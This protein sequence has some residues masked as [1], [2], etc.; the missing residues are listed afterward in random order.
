MLRAGV[1]ISKK[2]LFRFIGKRGPPPVSL[3]GT[4]TEQDA[5]TSSSSFAAAAPASASLAPSGEEP[6]PAASNNNQNNSRQGPGDLFQFYRLL[7]PSLD[8]E[9]GPY[10]LKETLLAK[11]LCHA[12]GR[13]P[14]SDPGAARVL[15]WQRDGAGATAG[16]LAHVARDELVSWWRGERVMEREE[17]ERERKKRKNSSSR[18]NQKNFKKKQFANGCTY[19]N[20]APLEERRLGIYDKP[21][22]RALTVGELNEQLDLLVR[23]ASRKGA[24]GR[25]GAAGGAGTGGGPSSS[26]LP[27]GDPDEEIGSRVSSAGKVLR[28]LMGKTSARTMTWIVKIILCGE[29]E[30]E[31]F[32]FDLFLRLFSSLF[33]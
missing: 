5:S 29:Q 16:S 23:R 19:K 12:L 22:Y 28:D 25:G 27:A 15:G 13:D 11:A 31:K 8:D 18:K 10:H 17:C 32:F 9:R 21:L 4:G 3:V 33:F 14:R 30:N 6:A 20:E 24:R 7:L 1:V 2:K 26:S